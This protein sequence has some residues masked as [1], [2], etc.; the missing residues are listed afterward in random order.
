MRCVW[1]AGVC[2][3]PGYGASELVTSP[4]G[5]PAGATG[6]CYDGTYYTGV[7]KRVPAGAIRV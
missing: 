5:A 4:A 6:L 3:Q 1:T 7:N 2:G